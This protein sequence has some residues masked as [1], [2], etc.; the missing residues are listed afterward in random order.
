MVVDLRGHPL[1]GSATSDHGITAFGYP[2]LAEVTVSNGTVKNF[3]VALGGDT[4]TRAQRVALV[5]SNV[6]FFC[7]GGCEAEP[8]PVQGQQDRAQRWR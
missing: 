5:D 4:A 2:G 1:S 7:N 6:G 8:R 3:N